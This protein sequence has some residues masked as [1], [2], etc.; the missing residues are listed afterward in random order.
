M[1][2]I[3][4][5]LLFGLALYFLP[6]IIGFRKSNAGAIFALNLLLGWTVIGWIVALVW[7]LTAETPPPAI[8]VQ[9]PIQQAGPG[10]ACPSCGAP[11]ARAHSYCPACGT[12]IA[13]PA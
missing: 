2:L 9:A 5:P 7:S 12:R 3:A 1:H 11:V 13:W 8:Y 4:I 10:W 6:T